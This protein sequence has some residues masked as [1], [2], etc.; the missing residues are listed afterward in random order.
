MMKLDQL[1]N[2]IQAGITSGDAGTLDADEI[3]RRGRAWHGDALRDT[4]RRYEA[5]Q[6]QSTERVNDIETFRTQIGTRLTLVTS[7]TC[8]TYCTRYCGST[9]PTSAPRNGR[10][11]MRVLQHEPISCC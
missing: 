11:R 4:E 10:H 9:S 5:G 1:R 8:R 7:M 3:K 2:D 6:Q